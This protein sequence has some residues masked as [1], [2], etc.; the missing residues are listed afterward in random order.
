MKSFEVLG[1]SISWFLSMFPAFVPLH[2]LCD[3]IF[4]F[5][6]VSVQVSVCARKEFQKDREEFKHP[7]GSKACPRTC[8][9]LWAF[10]IGVD[11]VHCTTETSERHHSPHGLGE[12]GC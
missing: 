3:N 7:Q 12:C 11:V 2:V 5:L 6:N 10:V 4:H 8:C 9:T 1:S